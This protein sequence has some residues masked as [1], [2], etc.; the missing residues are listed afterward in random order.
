MN[1][2]FSIIYVPIK[3]EAKERLSVGLFLRNEERVFF[4]YSKFKLSI[5]KDLISNSA[6]DL[7][8]LGLRNI[9]RAVIEENEELYKVGNSILDF[10]ISLNQ[11]L[12]ESYFGYLSRYSNNLL[13]FTNPENISTDANQKNYQILFSKLVDERYYN[14]EV[15]IENIDIVR[16]AKSTLKPL[17]KDRVNWDFD[18]TRKHVPKLILPSVRMDFIGKNGIIVAGQALDF[19]KKN[20]FLEN[21]ISKH[22]VLLDAMKQSN[23]SSTSFV[24]GKEP[25]KKSHPKNHKIW[26][27]LF[28]ES[29][30]EFVD[31]DEYERIN[32]YMVEHDVKPL[33]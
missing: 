23:G 5:V 22:I 9:K 24:L 28:E 4:E 12:K 27:N 26:K 1:T 7:V 16:L 20:Y 3:Q 17:I 29:R 18:I 32:E 15:L 2:F 31:T 21:D 8:Y 13:G 33:V 19:E 30:I 10:D 25:A 6:F 11:S 14:K